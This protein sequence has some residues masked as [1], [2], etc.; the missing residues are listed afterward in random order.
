M[1]LGTIAFLI[2]PLVLGGYLL[3]AYPRYRRVRVR[4]LLLYVVVMG[5]LIWGAL[6]FVAYVADMRVI[7]GEVVVILWFTIAWRLVWTI[8]TQTV[9]R[10]GQ[11]WVRWARLQRRRG[12][13]PPAV[14]R[15]IPWG[16]AMLTGVIFFPVFLSMVATHRCKLADGHDP[17]VYGRAFDAVRIPTADGLTLDG[18]FIPAAGAERTILVCHGAG[19]NKGNF[20]FFLDGL[21]GQG[22]NV[23]F[24]DFRAHGASDGRTATYGIRE[25]ADV[26]AA[27]DWLKRE[28]PEQ[29]RVIVGLGS[30]QG[31]M[32]L[33][34]AAAED[35]RIDAVILDSPFVSPRELLQEQARRVP[36]VGPVAA[37]WLLALAS[38]QT[39]TNFF[40]ASAERAVGALG[41]RPVLI[42]HGDGD[43]VMPRS[44]AQRLYDA[45][46]G[47]RELWFGPGAHSNIV[48]ADP[49][50]YRR[51]VTEFLDKSLGPAKG[52]GILPTTSPAEAG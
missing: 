51:R 4:S 15:F 7:P 23:A 20:L 16:R 21:P 25:R 5:G 43:F 31:S 46:R 50:E 6:R 36:V 39:W 52:W 45:A 24:F 35:P 49:Q 41:N 37:D 28:R 40:D 11:R 9:G 13:H 29:S 10:W 19:A 8:W 18:W 32:A 12:A 22:Y 42:I 17:S 44:H 3:W 38:L 27:V 34:L 1:D 33:A 2:A 26:R 47:P 30:S 48:T 14:I